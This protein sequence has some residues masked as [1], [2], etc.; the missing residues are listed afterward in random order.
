MGQFGINTPLFYI[1]RE[2]NTTEIMRNRFIFFAFLSLALIHTIN[3]F[4]QNESIQ[5]NPYEIGESVSFVFTNDNPV[6]TKHLNAKTWIAKTF[7]DYKSVIQFEDD[8]NFKLILKGHSDLP[9]ETIDMPQ[10]LSKI[11]VYYAL[12]YTI[13]IDSKEDKYRILFDDIRVNS[14]TE[15]F[16]L[17]NRESDI[18]A[19]KDRLVNEYC[20]PYTSNNAY[21]DWQKAQLDTLKSTLASLPEKGNHTIRMQKKELQNQISAQ[22]ESIRRGI[23]EQE[24]TARERK[25]RYDSIYS[26]FYGLVS[27]FKSTIEKSDDF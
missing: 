27:S 15:T 10:L 5:I 19:E 23:A 6:Q 22:E 1:C 13:T 14:K 26:V 24:K 3:S 17:G 2:Y 16:V 25:A 8:N 12:Y 11:D 18:D 9:K 4:G 21:L 20:K 7:G